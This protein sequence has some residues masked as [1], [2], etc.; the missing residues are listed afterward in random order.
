MEILAV[1]GYVDMVKAGEIYG[2]MMYCISIQAIF[3]LLITP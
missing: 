3:N 1:I 2:R